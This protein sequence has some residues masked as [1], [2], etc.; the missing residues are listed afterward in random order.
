M[1]DADVEALLE[2]YRP[3]DAPANL[4]ASIVAG[5]MTSPART[6]VWWPAAAAAILVITFYWLA[7]VERQSIAARFPD[8]TPLSSS[9]AGQVP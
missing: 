3:L 9:S 1:T 5:S 7:A 6:G 4:K 2:R 8:A